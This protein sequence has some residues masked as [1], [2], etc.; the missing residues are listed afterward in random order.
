MWVLG[1]RDAHMYMYHNHVIKPNQFILYHSYR[2]ILQ[3]SSPFPSQRA[4]N[5]PSP[6]PFFFFFAHELKKGVVNGARAVYL[7]YIW[8]GSRAYLPS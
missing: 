3:Y 2:G 8:A 6:P 7:C 5:P 1:H 4:Y